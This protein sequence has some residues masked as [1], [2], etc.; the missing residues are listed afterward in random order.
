MAF[1]NQERK[2]ELAPA[3]K[4]ILKKYGA[5]GSLKVRDYSTLVLTISES[6]FE[7]PENEDG[8]RI[9]QYYLS[10]NYSGEKLQFLKEL[11]EAM[12][13]GNHNNSDIQTDY[14][15]VGWYIEIRFGRWKRP[16]KQLVA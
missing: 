14:F 7:V 5:K 1:M 3:I 2:K 10:D 11:V 8:E 16:H 12:M 13:T 9:N 6:R 15:D 4:S